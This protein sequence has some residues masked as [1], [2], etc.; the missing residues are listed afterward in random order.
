MFPQPLEGYEAPADATTIAVTLPY[1]DTDPLDVYVAVAT[2][3]PSS[4]V[5]VSTDSN[6]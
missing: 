1:N 6:E 3:Y 2:S 5:V 4:D